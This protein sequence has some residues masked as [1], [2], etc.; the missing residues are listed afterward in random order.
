M[1]TKIAIGYRLDEIVN[2][3]TGNTY[4]AFEPA[5]D[6]VVLKI[7][8]WPFDKFSVADRLLGTQMKA[9]GEVMAIERTLE[10]ALMKAVR[11]LDLGIVCLRTRMFDHLS[12][13][14]LL[15]RMKVA[16]DE[17][18]FMVA[19]GI[20]RGMPVELIAGATWI[21]RY[22]VE[23]IKN[24]VDLETTLRAEAG[25]RRA[26]AADQRP[27]AEAAARGAKSHM[28]GRAS[29]GPASPS[30]PISREMLLKAKRIGFADAE[31]AEL[32]N[33]TEKAIR[34][35]RRETAV[36]PVYKLVD[37]CAGEFAAQTPYFYSTYETEDEAP[38][39]GSGKVV[40]L[41]GGPIRIGQ[42]IEFDYCAVHAVWAMREAGKPA[43]IINNNRK[44]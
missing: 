35:L 39:L 9:T 17:R 14:E 4:A 11:S 31:L 28:P 33:T 21:D 13:A 15:E 42:G 24:I 7:P 5:L 19:D 1:T 34:Q 6:Y 40:V 25:A 32:L 16:E 30:L 36:Q 10:A 2:A 37:T 8:R 20:R 22:F 18:L 38:T 41:G 43:I 27:E 23:K 44:R 26:K 29:A 12:E 3:V